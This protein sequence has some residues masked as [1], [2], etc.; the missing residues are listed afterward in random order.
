MVV[1]NIL[2]AEEHGAMTAIAESSAFEFRSEAAAAAALPPST[3]V[4]GFVDS[5]MSYG[6]TL[7][8]VV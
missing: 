7:R 1:K 2:A 5:E 3:E 8:E 6:P 4:C